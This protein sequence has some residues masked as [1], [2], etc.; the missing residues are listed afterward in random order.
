MTISFFDYRNAANVSNFYLLHLAIAIFSH[1]HHQV[2]VSG[3]LKLAILVIA[4]S[5]NNPINE[6]LQTHFAWQMAKCWINDPKIINSERC[7][8]CISRGNSKNNNQTITFA[9]M[10]LLS[11]VLIYFS[12]VTL[13]VWRVCVRGRKKC[14]CAFCGF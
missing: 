12:R 5:N 14:R 7:I 10:C 2:S 3:L 8:L 4:I 11:K 13:F 1:H 9:R 6:R